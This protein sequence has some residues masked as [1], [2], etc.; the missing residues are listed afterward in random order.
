[1]GRLQVQK[2]W[3]YA[4]TPLFTDTKQ[5][6]TSHPQVVAHL[7]TGAGA[8]L[9]LPLRRHDLGIDTR[10]VDTGVQAGALF[11]QYQLKPLEYPCAI[12]SRN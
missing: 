8:D 1:M 11:C 7:D 3:T 9:E 12:C 2:Q 6:E 4:D 5:E 10:D